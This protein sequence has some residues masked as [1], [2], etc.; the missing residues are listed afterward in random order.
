M[1]AGWHPRLFRTAPGRASVEFSTDL[2]RR[3]Q[4]PHPA[5]SAFAVGRF[6]AWRRSSIKRPLARV[7]GGDRVFRFNLLRNPPASADV[8]LL[9]A[10]N[11]TLYERARD[12]G[13]TRMTSSAIPFS[14]SDWIQHHGPA[15][16][17]F[18]AA[19]QRFDPN[20]VLNPG[21]GIFPG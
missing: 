15:W 4:F 8:A 6:A 13:G 5:E 2:D 3:F 18:R 11:R 10:M 9:V 16:E 7:P 20:N 21:A 12:I 17:P 14:H 1:G 19:K